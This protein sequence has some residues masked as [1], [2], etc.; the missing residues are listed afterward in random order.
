MKISRKLLIS[1]AVITAVGLTS[2]GTTAVFA[3]AGTRPS[4]IALLAQKLGI[5]QSKV[6]TAFD[7]IKSERQTTMQQK[8]QDRLVKDGKLTEVQKQAVLTEFAS[9]KSKYGADALKNMTPSERKQ[10]FADEQNELKS[11]AQ[12][13]G[14]DLSLIKPGM[15]MKGM[16]MH[17]RGWMR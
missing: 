11:W 5:D 7:Q 2:M 17:F 3:Q 1:G 9:L 14:I 8:F 13:Q 16:G 6:Q 12:S 4:L 10:A 15:Q